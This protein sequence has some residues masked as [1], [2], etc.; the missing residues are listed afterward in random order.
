MSA[1]IIN[2]FGSI[3]VSDQ[4]ITNIASN[5]AMESYGIV[6]LVNA[7]TT[8]TILTLLKK[9]NLSKGVTVTIE[10][11]KITIDLSVILEHGVQISV[12]SENIIETVKFNVEEKTG[13]K[14]DKV[15][16]LVRD[17]R[18]QDQEEV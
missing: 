6:G 8:N 17:I 9:D 14:V 16:I 13:I 10:N 4:V 12:V 15:N 2:E 7:N 1:H 5:V 3:T 18:L 11:N